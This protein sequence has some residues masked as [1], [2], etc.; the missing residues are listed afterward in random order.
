[1]KMKMLLLLMLSSPLLAGPIEENTSYDPTT[2]PRTSRAS[3][4]KRTSLRLFRLERMRLTGQ[5]FL[6]LR[7][8]MAPQYAPTAWDKYADAEFDWNILGVVFMENRVHL[9]TLHTGQVKT[10]GWQWN[11]GVSVGYGVDV[12]YSHHSQH[13]LDEPDSVAC[14]RSNCFPVDDRYGLRIT[15]YEDKGARSGIFK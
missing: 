1:M 11:L 5:Q 15:V 12:M 7:E 13:L 8:P 14:G 9:A 10:A 4:P 2:D 3:P 6:G